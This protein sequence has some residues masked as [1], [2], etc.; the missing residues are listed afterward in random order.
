ME[1]KR[2]FGPDLTRC[3]AAI[4]VLAVHF[5]LNDGFYSEPFSG[6]GMAAGAVFRMAFMTCVPLFMVLSGYLCVDRRWSRGYLRGL[7]PVVLTY[8]LAAAVC[9]LFRMV[10]L[11]QT[12][13]LGG[14]VKSVLNFS[15]APYGWYVEM[16][17]G[18]FLLMPFVN[19]AWHNLEERGKRALVAVLVIVTV[20]PTFVN[21]MGQILPDWWT[22]IYPLTYYVTGA[23]LREH[24]LRWKKS[25]L[26]LGWLG[27]SAFMG[28]GQYVYQNL[29]MS[30]AV[31]QVAAGNYWGSLV[32]LVETVCLFSILSQ[33][34]GARCPKWIQRMVAQVAR[35]SLPLYLMS[36][37]TDQII[38][39]PLCGAVPT[40]AGRLVYLPL[41]VAVSLVL[42]GA[43]AQC[44][45]W[46][47]KALMRLIPKRESISV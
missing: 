1:Q 32:T 38:Y 35:L 18:L 7:L 41:M 22:G 14:L 6:A 26:L 30:G 34:E 36:Y 17:I 40:A 45:D 3:V 19:A 31:F 15:A 21:Q 46:A 28:V 29:A 43:M 5:F 23:W 2:S 16:Y 42:S 33:C 27:L 25:W 11:G 12:L 39:P 9:L 47:V 44:V 4:L 8:L 13:S 20:L 37:I 24:P 10:Y